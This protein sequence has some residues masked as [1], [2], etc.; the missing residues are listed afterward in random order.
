M[1]RDRLNLLNPL[2]LLLK[3]T[4]ALTSC[5]YLSVAICADTFDLQKGQLK[6]PAV[7]VGGTIY[8]DAVVTIK[9]VLAVGKAPKIADYDRYDFK[10][11]QLLIPEVLVGTNPYYN[12]AVTLKDVVSVGG[13]YSGR[14][15]ANGF[16]VPM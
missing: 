7:E 4:L 6:I 14:L 1:I 9:E 12:V 13:T 5:F 8:K 2:R 10:K 16:T 3:S 15:Q 11:G